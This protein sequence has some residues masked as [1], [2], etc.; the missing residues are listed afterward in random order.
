MYSD[1]HIA[2]WSY[3]A[4][5]LQSVCLP[6]QAAKLQPES[7]IT[8]RNVEICYLSSVHWGWTILEKG[9]L[10]IFLSPL[11][12]SHILSGNCLR[13]TCR[14]SGENSNTDMFDIADSVI[15]IL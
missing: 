12:E 10:A 8:W 6:N 1:F 14:V 15:L 7:M 11:T 13:C 5:I 2:A 4:E 9:L 3:V